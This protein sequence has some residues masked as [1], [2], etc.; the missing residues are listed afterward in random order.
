MPK[1]KIIFVSKAV[2]QIK[3]CILRNKSV[4]VI[5]SKIETSISCNEQVLRK[6]MVRTYHT[7]ASHQLVNM[8]HMPTV[9]CK[10]LRKHAYSNK[11]KISPSKTESFQIKNSNILHI[12]ARNIDCWY[13]L[14]P[15]RRDG[16]NEYP[17]S[18]FF[19]QK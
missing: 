1:K 13:S 12:S 2:C 11:L 8:L 19:E 14:E 9:V 10:P 15:T 4:T 16:S 6:C 3:T 7:N 17:Q 5:F 18:L